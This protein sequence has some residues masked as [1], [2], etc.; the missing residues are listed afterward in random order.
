M[1]SPSQDQ[2]NLLNLYKSRAREC[3]PGTANPH[4]AEAEIT[5]GGQV[6]RYATIRLGTDDEAAYC[7]FLTVPEERPLGLD[8]TYDIET[9][10][11]FPAT[12]TRKNVMSPADK[13]RTEVELAELVEAVSR[14][15][16]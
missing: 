9:A 1:E 15:D 2:T 13:E 5:V 6:I 7:L 8:E 4:G 14:G 11:V 10:I 16:F 12:S 3:P